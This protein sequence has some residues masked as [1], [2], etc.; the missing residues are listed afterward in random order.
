MNDPAAWSAVRLQ[1]VIV[2][3]F[4]AA[5]ALA[6]AQGSDAHGPLVIDAPDLGGLDARSAALVLSGMQSGDLPVQVA[7]ATLPGT[8]EDGARNVLLLLETSGD[9]LIAAAGDDSEL[10]VELHAYALGADGRVYDSRTR[11][12]R[13]DLA[14]HG[15]ALRAEGLE[16]LSDFRLPPGDYSLRVLLLHRRSG[17]FALRVLDHSIAPV[18]SRSPGDDGVD[19]PLFARP[20]AGKLVVKAGTPALLESVLEAPVL[21]SAASRVVVG[22]TPWIW[23]AG[24]KNETGLEAIVRAADDR[25]VAHYSLA[26]RSATATPESGALVARVGPLDLPAGEYR[27][28]VG[29]S[30]DAVGRERHFVLVTAH[31]PDRATTPGESEPERRRTT[32][33]SQ[34]SEVRAALAAYRASLEPAGPDGR[35]WSFD[36]LLALETSIVGGRDVERLEAAEIEAVRALARRSPEALVPLLYLYGELYPVYVESERYDAAQHAGTFVRLLARFYDQ[37]SRDDDRHRLSAAALASLGGFRQQAGAELEAR[38]TYLAALELDET[39][40]AALVGAACVHESFGDYRTAAELLRRARRVQPN[41]AE[42]QLRLAINELRLDSKRAVRSLRQLTAGSAPDWVSILAY[43]ELARILVADGRLS[44][45]DALLAEAMERHPEN[46]RLPIQRVAV[47]DRLHRPAE[48]RRALSRIE[49]DTGN[50]DTPRLR[51]TGPPRALLDAARRLVAAAAEKRR[52]EAL[53]LLQALVK[54][55]GE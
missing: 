35:D 50:S 7:A 25:A 10:V 6:A 37:T 45:A 23:I 33:P 8:A 19:A 36:A 15:E 9:S 40:V 22:T 39:Q 27:L 52:D 24:T 41:L 4:A 5:G 53:R 31:G 46:Q 20:A 26:S 32:R 16:L 1:S 18:D 13:L 3:L 2:L 21:P 42:I 47:L 17:H 49:P 11:A 38:S 43:Q 48:A 34:S 51:Y 30:D 14:I 44:E 29:S 28:R 55:S 54:E 12:F